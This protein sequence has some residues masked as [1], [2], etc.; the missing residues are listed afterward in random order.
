MENTQLVAKKIMTAEN[1]WDILGMEKDIADAFKKLHDDEV[2]LNNWFGVQD[3][4]NTTITFSP[5]VM[6]VSQI[7]TPVTG[8]QPDNDY[9]REGPYRRDFFDPYSV[10]RYTTKP[11]IET[12]VNKNLLGTVQ[13]SSRMTCLGPVTDVVQVQ[14]NLRYEGYYG[15]EYQHEYEEPKYDRYTTHLQVGP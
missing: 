13:Q 15:E 14:R 2:T 12:P 5:S 7:A 8:N 11:V 1:Q 9:P 6:S 4:S 10:P 3:G